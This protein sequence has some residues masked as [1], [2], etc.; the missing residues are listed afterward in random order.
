MVFTIVGMGV[1][2]PGKGV[3]GRVLLVPAEA[4]AMVERAMI[5]FI[6]DVVLLIS[7]LEEEVV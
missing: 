7:W 4:R 1:G 5:D 6:F 3:R 2:R